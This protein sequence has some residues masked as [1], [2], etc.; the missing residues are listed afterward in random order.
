MASTVSNFHP[1]T[2]GQWWSL[3]LD[4]GVQS[5]Y[6]EG[7][8]RQTNIT[9]IC[10]KCSQCLGHTGFALSSR[11][12]S[13]PSLHCSGSR[14]LCQELSE[15]SP[16]LSVLPRSK[17]L[18]FRFSGTPQRRRLD[19]AC[20]LCPSPVRA[21]QVTRCLAGCYLSPPSAQP[22][23]FLGVQQA[24]LLRCACLLWGA[25][26][27]LRPSR[28]TSTVRNPKES[29]LARKPACSLVDDASLGL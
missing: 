19:W 23:S 29:W 14:L 4:L 24:R 11:H 22:L 18:R 21:A 3:F 20:I 28:Q 9:G 27:W 13:F 5:C 1:D 15:A 25:D 6:G 7:G 16:G 12:M 26:L 10:G 17:L 2:R 8:T